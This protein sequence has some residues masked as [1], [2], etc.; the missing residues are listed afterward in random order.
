AFT[1]ATV[2]DRA[3]RSVGNID[4]IEL[5]TIGQRKGL[6]LRGGDG[7]PMYAVDVDVPG[8]TVVVGDERD[9]LEPT[10]TLRDVTWAA[11][12]ETLG[13]VFAQCSAHGSA[14]A[15]TFDP[16]SNTLTWASPYRRVAPGQAVVL[17]D[18]DEVL[19]GGLA[20]SRSRAPVPR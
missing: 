18:G 14:L 20:V 9:L 10:T 19:G 8:A 13:A 11:G 5:V 16:S 4:A 2:V 6:G 15:A 12:V 3:G 7:E 17:Y 1:P